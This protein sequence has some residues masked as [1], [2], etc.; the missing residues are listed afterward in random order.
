MPPRATVQVCLHLPAGLHTGQED[1]G[2]GQEGARGRPGGGQGSRGQVPRLLQGPGGL[3]LVLSPSSIPRCDWSG[4]LPGPGPGVRQP[5]RPRPPRQLRGR[6][7]PGLE[8]SCR[9]L[10][11][12]AWYCGKLG[13]KL[14]VKI[15]S[16]FI[17]SRRFGDTPIF[18]V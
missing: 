15:Y 10:D 8:S 1:V 5:R 16:L 18:G 9:R 3:S 2:R 6:G 13:V 4:Q 12:E 7:G 17:I 14:S 11:L